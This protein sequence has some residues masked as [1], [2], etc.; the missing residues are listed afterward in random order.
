MRRE[1]QKKSVEGEARN[2]QINRE[3]ERVED[4]HPPAC[5]PRVC[6]RTAERLED[7]L[8]LGSS[9]VIAC[10]R[11]WLTSQVH[12]FNTHLIIFRRGTRVGKGKAEIHTEIREAR[13]YGECESFFSLPNEAAGER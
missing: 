8:V 12:V 5:V 4:A 9:L 6:V 1:E 13:Q 7:Y 11:A 2:L 3:R 10:V